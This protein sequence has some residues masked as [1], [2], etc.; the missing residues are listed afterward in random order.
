MQFE[1]VETGG[2]YLVE[3]S[4]DRWFVAT[5][6]SIVFS[7]SFKSVVMHMVTRMGFEAD[8]ID[9]GIKELMKMQRTVE[10]NAIHFGMYKTF[11]FTCNKG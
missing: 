3:A 4:N 7:G 6:Q 8:D 11:I 10:H 1:K 5:K 2:Y 9:V